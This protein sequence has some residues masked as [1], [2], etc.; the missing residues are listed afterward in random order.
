MQDVQDTRHRD[1]LNEIN[2]RASKSPAPDLEHWA[3]KKEVLLQA[4]FCKSKLCL[5]NGLLPGL[6][7]L[8]KLEQ[9]EDL[10]PP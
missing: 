9:A 7:A 8:P 6:E 3:E 1:N 10:Q 4:S 2:A 5:V